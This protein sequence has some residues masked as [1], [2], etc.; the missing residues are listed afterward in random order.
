[1]QMSQGFTPDIQKLILA[2]EGGYVDHPKDPGGATNLGITFAVL[3]AWYGRKITKQDV[4]NL[5]RQ[6]ALDIYKAQYWDKASCSLLPLGLDYMVMDYGVNSGPSRAIKD[7]QRIVGVAADGVP[8][9]IT[10]EAVKQFVARKGIQKL[11][12]DYAERRWAFMQGLSNFPSF[13]KGWKKRVWGN[14]MGAQNN[15]IGVVDRAMKMATGTPVALLP[16]PEPSVGLA[17]PEAPSNVELLKD[18]TALTGFAGAVATVFGAI[19]N[20]PL[21]QIAAVAAIGIVVFIYL[22]RRKQEDPT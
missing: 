6:T 8:G 14:T 22:K 21:L 12:L 5:S 7:L 20:Q 9:A 19:Q 4:K 16:L 18:P 13:G 11:L 10:V 17:K 3:Q 15:D 1:M 2:H